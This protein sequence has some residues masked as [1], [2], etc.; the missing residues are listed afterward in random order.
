MSGCDSEFEDKWIEILE[1]TYEHLRSKFKEK[2]TIHQN[3]SNLSFYT[4]FAKC[5]NPKYYAQI[6][7]ETPIIV[8]LSRTYKILEQRG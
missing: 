3:C 1:D 2:Y 5:K 8:R 7:I 6:K 4:R